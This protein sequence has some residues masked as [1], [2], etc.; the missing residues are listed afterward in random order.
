MATIVNARDVLLQGSTRLVYVPLPSN[1][2]PDAV[3]E[4]IL[5]PS[6]GVF[7]TDASGGTTTP[8]SITLTLTR[9][10]VTG[11]ATFSVVEGTA[12]LTGTGDTRTLTFANMSSERV[13]VRATVVFNS[14][15]YT[16]N[17]TI[18]KVKDGA[19]GTNGAN[20]TNGVDG[21]RGSVDLYVIGSAWSDSVANN[22]ILTNTGSAIKYAGDKVTIYN[23]AGFAQTKYWDGISA[24]TAGQIINGNVLVSG[25]VTSNAIGTNT[26][27]AVNIDT[28]GR[29][30]AEGDSV[31]YAGYPQYRGAIFGVNASLN[32]NTDYRKGVVGYS[33]GGAGISGLGDSGPS[34][35]YGSAIGVQGVG[36]SGGDFRSN[37][38]NGLGVYGQGPT[39]GM[40]VS[41]TTNGVG[42]TCSASGA[43]SLSLKITGTA[44]VQ[45]G[46]YV[47]SN[48][49]G[50]DWVFMGADGTWHRPSLS[51]IQPDI[52]DTPRFQFS[53]DNGAT[54]TTIHLRRI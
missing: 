16:A 33:L 35:T 22:A 27:S 41:N 36:W 6:T 40:F 39:A 15:T 2:V 52:N 46:S 3:R 1:L 5:S 14:V 24:W 11:T 28:T 23:N 51:S 4:I 21:R 44:R 48:P 19:A 10:Y 50:G 30:K 18:V 43:S 13:V 12:T 25:T 38:V 7:K 49:P 26:L 32:G 31:A 53:T 42:V 9:K 37:T 8:T 29:I 17:S 47:Y 54:W 20:G 45:W 34:G